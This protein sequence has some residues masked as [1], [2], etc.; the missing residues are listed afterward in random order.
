MF[1]I[2]ENGPLTIR[3]ATNEQRLKR[4]IKRDVTAWGYVDEEC[5]YMICIYRFKLYILIH[6]I[7]HT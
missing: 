3:E 6:L 1:K 2:Y 7:S 4:E 5:V